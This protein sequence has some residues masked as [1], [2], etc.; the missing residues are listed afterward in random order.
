MRTCIH[1]DS[2]HDLQC[3]RLCRRDFHDLLRPEALAWGILKPGLHTFPKRLDLVARPVRSGRAV[4]Q[5][6]QARRQWP[7]ETGV[8]FYVV[9]VVTYA[10]DVDNGAFITP[11]YPEEFDRI[12]AAQHDEIRFFDTGR[13]CSAACEHA[14]VLIV[15]FIEHAFGLVGRQQRAAEGFGERTDRQCGGAVPGLQ[16]GDEDWP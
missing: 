3:T 13:F 11:R 16:S 15:G 6:R 8:G 9:N 10:C 14:H 12:Q 4:G 2:G 7:I 1:R 5:L